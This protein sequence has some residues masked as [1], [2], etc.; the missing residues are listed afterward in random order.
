[1]KEYHGT[2]DCFDR[3]KELERNE[4]F[5][6]S[7]FKLNSKKEVYET[8]FDS[9]GNYLFDNYKEVNK[10]MRGEAYDRQ[11]LSDE[12]Q[13][14]W[15]KSN[16]IFHYIHDRYVAMDPVEEKRVKEIKRCLEDV[17]KKLNN[18]YA[19][20][21]H[22]SSLFV[23]G[24]YYPEENIN[25]GDDIHK[26]NRVTI[27]HCKVLRQIEE[28]MNKYK[29]NSVKYLTLSLMR[30]KVEQQLKIDS[31][32][33][34]AKQEQERIRKELYYSTYYSDDTDQEE[35][36]RK[37]REKDE[38]KRRE[39]E[40]RKRR[41]EEERERRELEASSRAL[42]ERNYR[43]ALEKWEERNFDIRIFY[44]FINEDGDTFITNT[45]VTLS[46]EEALHILSHA[47]HSLEQYV[48]LGWGDSL[49][50]IKDYEINSC[51]YDPRPELEDYL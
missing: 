46:R 7:F 12:M 30:K 10:M 48:D 25:K 8:Y 41:E 1:M 13:S 32:I 6:S 20:G 34:Q 47:P 45:T 4:S 33:L 11:V 50:E 36:E 35:E 38:R 42:S 14:V 15:D 26:M 16:W 31:A 18:K 3:Y 37:R 44:T 23:D 39:E 5:F 28:A 29:N 24:V 19:N 9:R 49:L 43:R 21:P 40:E 2:S 22:Y 17:Y 27:K 51:V